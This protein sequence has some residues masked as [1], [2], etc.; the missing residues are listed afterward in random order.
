MNFILI[1]ICILT[2]LK[3]W[4]AV[5]H[6]VLNIFLFFSDF[7]IVSFYLPEIKQNVRKYFNA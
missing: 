6:F 2:Q 1:F 4:N 5:Q 7:S 3:D